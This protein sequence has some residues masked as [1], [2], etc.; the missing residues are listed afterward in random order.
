MKKSVRIVVLLF[1]LCSAVLPSGASGGRKAMKNSPATG[2]RYLES[3]FHLYDSLQKRIWNYAETAYNERKSAEQWAS[4]LEGE[5]FKVERGV[6]G[7]PT[8][9]VASYGE[10]S[11]VIGMMAEYDAL[12]GMSQ[13]TVAYR[14]ALVEGANGHGCGHNLLGTGSVAGAVAV[15]KWLAAG[16]KGTVKLFGCPAEEGG[17]GKAYMMREGVFEG[18]DAMLDW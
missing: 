5:G 15:A 1:V 7:I 17:G 16:H 11:P 18:L 4:F 13:D 2:L 3:S 12:A 8:A 9:F 14:K 6:A 10:G